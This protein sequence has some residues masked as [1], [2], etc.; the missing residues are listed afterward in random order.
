MVV[1]PDDDNGVT[2]AQ[3]RALRDGVLFLNL[4]LRE[5]ALKSKNVGLIDSAT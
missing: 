5:V 1:R 2:H 3:L 4:L